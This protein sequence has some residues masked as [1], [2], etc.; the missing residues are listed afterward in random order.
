METKGS[1]SCIHTLSKLNR[2]YT[3]SI[4]GLREEGPGNEAKIHMKLILT[5]SGLLVG[6]FPPQKWCVYS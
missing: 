4:A 3:I 6:E 2:E 1:V 5:W